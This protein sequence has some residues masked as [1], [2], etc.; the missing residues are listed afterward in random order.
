MKLLRNSLAMAVLIGGVV[1]AGAAQAKGPASEIA[2]LGGDLT[3]VGAEKA[4]NKDGSIPAWNG[5]LT[6]PPAGWSPGQP[7]IDPFAGEKPLFTI[8]GANAAQYKDKLSPGQLALL[9]RYSNFAMPVYKTRRTAAYPA[10]VLEQVKK[11]AAGVEIEGSGIKGNTPGASYPFP[12]P[13]TGL[14]VI[15]NHLLRYAGG[16]VEDQFDTFIVRPNGD[17]SSFG[18]R[19]RRYNA[20]NLDAPKPT[21]LLRNLL[22]YTHP[23]SLQGTVYLVQDPVDQVNQSRAA[24][25][26]NAGLR[27]VRRAPDLAYDMITDGGEGLYFVD[28]V[29]AYNG[30]PDRYDWKLIGKKEMYVAYNTYKMG[31]KKLKYAD[32]I[33]KNTVNSEN[34]RYELHRVWV[35]EGVLK[36]GQSHQYGKRTFYVDEDTWHILAEDAYDNRGGLWRAAIHGVEQVYGANTP[37]YSF[38]LYHDLTSG[39]YAIWGLSNESSYPRTFGQTGKVIDFEPDA[40]RRQGLK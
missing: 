39:A 5:G 19:M 35:V 29:D 15:W 38:N 33:R 1:I 14:E 24:W 28:Q 20:S 2:R 40:L 13:T 31:D 26:Y 37:Y 16:S 34:M 25:I 10:A 18:L 11:Q 3:P 23:A 32:I 8:T 27:R 7:L 21:E 36:S 22:F 12:V 17:Y 30:G 6:Q 4:G 9:Q